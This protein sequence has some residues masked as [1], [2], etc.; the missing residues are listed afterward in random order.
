MRT[1]SP[2]LGLPEITLAE[3]QKE[4]IPVRVAV[5]KYEDGNEG[6]I[7][8]WELGDDDRARIAAGEDLYMGLLTFGKPM[9]P[10]SLEV[11]RPGWAPA[12]EE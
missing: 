7:L 8:R 12:E 3:E 4:Y 1:V 10:V 2:K 9:Q 5:V 6:V 11:G